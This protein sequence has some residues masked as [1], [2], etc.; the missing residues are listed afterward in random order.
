MS[1]SA[2]QRSLPKLTPETEVNLWSGPLLHRLLAAV[3]YFLAFLGSKNIRKVA[4]LLGILAFDILRLRRALVLKN[5]GYFNEY[6]KT[7]HPARVMSHQ[8]VVCCGREST[9]RFIQT[10]LEFFASPRL[11][12]NV[13]PHTT[14]GEHLQ[15][16]LKEGTGAYAMSIHLG[17]FELGCSHVS[18]YFRIVKAIT[19]L[20]GKGGIASF[21]MKI[22]HINGEYEITSLEKGKRAEEIR[23]AL[24]NQ[25]VIGF[26]ADQR[27]NNGLRVPFMGRNALT[28]TGLFYLW[29]QKPAPIIPIYAYRNAQ[30]TTIHHLALLPKVKVVENPLWTEEQFLYENT[31]ALNS[32]IAGIVAQHPAD[33]FWMH[34]RFKGSLPL[35]GA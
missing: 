6:L 20:V 19:K 32:L 30:D 23:K 9:I 5:L 26:M 16:A 7:E 29:K 2:Q 15:E 3:S 21:V 33:Y 4:Y 11:F 34:N 35:S 13:R 12:A 1:T 27:R 18:K 31:L 24:E 22:R 14:G 17:N 25:E 10:T 28:N 8:E